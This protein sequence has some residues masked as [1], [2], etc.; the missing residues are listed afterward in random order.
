MSVL[1][2]FALLGSALM[3]LGLVGFS[4]PVIAVGMAL[5]VLCLVALV[6]S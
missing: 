3:L 2:K 1:N 6:L 5:C 4:L